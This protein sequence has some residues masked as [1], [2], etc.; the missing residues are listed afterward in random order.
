MLLGVNRGAAAQMLV[1]LRKEYDIS[2]KSSANGGSLNPINGMDLE[3]DG[4]DIEAR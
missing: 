3:Y 1:K 2:E 4:L